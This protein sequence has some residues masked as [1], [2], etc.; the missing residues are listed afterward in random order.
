MGGFTTFNA[1]VVGFVEA[2]WGDDEDKNRLCVPTPQPNQPRDWVSAMCGILRSLA[3]QTAEPDL[4]E[5]SERS[6][7]NLTRGMADHM[8]D[9][10]MQAAM[11]L[12]AE[13]MEPALINAERLLAA[14]AAPRERSAT[15]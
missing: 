6:R 7:L 14:S 3:T 9:P 11:A 15:L 8:S 1:A 4:A 13:H 5:W 12:W 2:A 10:G